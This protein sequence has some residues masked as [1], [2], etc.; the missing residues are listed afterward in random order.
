MNVKFIYSYEEHLVVRIS[1]PNTIE[2]YKHV[3]I[4]KRNVS[5]FFWNQ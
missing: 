4:K 2:K 5:R 1:K 3:E